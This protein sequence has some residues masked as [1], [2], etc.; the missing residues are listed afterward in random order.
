MFH[1]A[2]AAYE[3]WMAFRPMVRTEPRVYDLDPAV[4]DDENEITISQACGRVWN[5]TDLI[6]REWAIRLAW[7]LDPVLPEPLPLLSNSYAFGARR[8]KPII[9][10]TLAQAAAKAA[11]ATASGESKAPDGAKKQSSKPELSIDQV[12]EEAMAGSLSV[13][14]E[15]NEPNDPEI[16][17]AFRGLVELFEPKRR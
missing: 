2:I 15:P 3:G 6:P 4:V 11:T 12:F 8:F 16:D 7:C 10:F 5:C 9:A 17:A 1:D 14:M 13:P